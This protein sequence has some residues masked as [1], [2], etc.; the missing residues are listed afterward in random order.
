MGETCGYQPE[1]HHLP[2]I[3]APWDHYCMI[4]IVETENTGDT[5]ESLNSEENAVSSEIKSFQRNR[6]MTQG[7]E[8]ESSRSRHAFKSERK[9]FMTNLQRYGQEYRKPSISF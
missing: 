5:D 4:S 9:E 7:F 6:K 3:V 2:L 8:G 1:T